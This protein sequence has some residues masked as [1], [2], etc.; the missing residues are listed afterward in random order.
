MKGFSLN[1]DDVVYL[2]ENKS[3][4]GKTF[5]VIEM[6]VNLI[7][8]LGREYDTNTLNAWVHDGLLCEVMR[9]DSLGWK[10][11]RVKL[12]L[13]FIPDEPE[14]ETALLLPSQV[15]SPLDDLRAELFNNE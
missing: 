4:L 5:K 11:G 12:S 3:P 6:T 7:N 8:R 10:R 15:E 14:Q 9:V 2:D 13:E 1:R